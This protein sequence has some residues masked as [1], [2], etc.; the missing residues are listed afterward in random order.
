GVGDDDVDALGHGDLHLATDL[1]YAEHQLLDPLDIA[2]GGSVDAAFIGHRPG[3]QHQGFTLHASLALDA[4]PDF[5]GDE[6]HER[7]SQAQDHFQ[8]AY[9]G[10]AGATLALDGRVLVPQ[11]RLDQ[12][13]V[14]GAVLIPDELVERLGGQVEAEGIELAGDFGFGAL[15]LADDPAIHRGQ[16]DLF[17]IHASVLAIGVLDDEVGGVPQLVAEVAVTL[18]AAHVELHVAAGGGQRAEGEAQGVGAVAGDAFGEL[19][20]G[21]L[22]DLLGQLGLHHAAGAFFQQLV[23][24]DAVDDIQ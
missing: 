6:R 8:H 9:Q 1:A 7:V 22:G 2:F 3:L 18:D 14:P 11:H 23:E 21:L 10:A 17:A 5:F 19:G 12:L 15:Q 24:G 16:L 4:L 13:Q 20:L